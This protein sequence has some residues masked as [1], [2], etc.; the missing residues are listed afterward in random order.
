MDFFFFFFLSGGRSH[1]P[2]VTKQ[3]SEKT[4]SKSI[5][6]LPDIILC[7]TNCVSLFYL[8]VFLYFF[9]LIFILARINFITRLKSSQQ[10]TLL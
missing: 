8:D 4:Q 5:F 10:P 9:K 6:W 3:D 2:T 7:L 1:L